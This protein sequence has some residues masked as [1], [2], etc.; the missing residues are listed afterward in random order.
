MPSRR[1]LPR[2]TFSSPVAGKLSF[3]GA[4]TT[5]AS[6]IAATNAGGTVLLGDGAYDENIALGG[7]SMG[8]IGQSRAGVLINAVS[9]AYGID[10]QDGSFVFKNFSMKG[11][12]ATGSY[13]IKVAGDAATAIVESV[14]VDDFYRTQLDFN[15]LSSVSLK[16]V[17]ATNADYGNGITLTDSDNA[18]LHDITTSGNACGRC[19]N[20]HLR[21]LR[22]RRLEEP[23]P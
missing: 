6:L 17:S 4:G 5:V 19:G 14:S 1:R 15:G 8:I 23:P 18:T 16:S 12:G 20:L 7:K 21:P 13:G 11:L 2:T 9:S 10:A 22:H 3:G